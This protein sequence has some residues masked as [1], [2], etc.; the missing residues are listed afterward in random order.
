MA[1]PMVISGGGAG[2]DQSQH[3]PRAGH[4]ATTPSAASP[5]TR[6]NTD[7]DVSS[8]NGSQTESIEREIAELVKDEDRGRLRELL[9]QWYDARAR[10]DDAAAASRQSTS[11]EQKSSVDIE[12]IIAKTVKATLAAQAPTKSWAS[13]ASSAPLGSSAWQPR[14]VVPEKRERQV[15]ITAGPGKTLAEMDPKRAVAAVNAAMRGGD[16]LAAQ[17][18]QSGDMVVTFKGTA[19]G[20]DDTWVAAAFGP[21]AMLRHREVAVIAKGVPTGLLLAAHDDQALTAELRADNSPGILRCRRDLPKNTQAAH[22]SLIVYLSSAS[23]AQEIICR[24]LVWQARMFDCEPFDPNLRFLQCF[25][26]YG[27]GHRARVCKAPA[28]CGHCAGG[29]HA[30]GENSCPVKNGD[31]VRRCVNCKGKHPAWDRT[32]PA[33]RT[34]RERVKE[35][36]A[37][38]ARRFE[39]ASNATTPSILQSSYGAT[40]ETSQQDCAS[41]ADVAWEVVQSRQASRPRGRPAGSTSRQLR[42]QS[43]ITSHLRAPAKRMRTDSAGAAPHQRDGTPAEASEPSI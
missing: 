24:G 34:E 36:Y 19:V 11:T 13:V 15:I 38:R 25:N 40:S 9:H 1:D 28:R 4:S 43:S 33:A 21:D 30:K 12:A 17:R 27:Y 3:H 39:I 14:A 23:A 2:L 8:K 41:S 29:A 22:S 32:C 26:C 42:S 35:A 10:L 16:A 5:A 37:H 20:R 6:G 7:T 18:L 31:R